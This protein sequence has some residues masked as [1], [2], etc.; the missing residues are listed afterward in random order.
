MRCVAWG[1]STAFG[2][3]V[4]GRLMQAFVGTAHATDYKSSTFAPNYLLVVCGKNKL[5]YMPI[6]R[7]HIMFIQEKLN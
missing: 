7:K 4:V 3:H 5:F 6:G 2:S 1:K